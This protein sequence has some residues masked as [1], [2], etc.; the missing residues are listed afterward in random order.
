MARIEYY[1]AIVVH[2]STE[3]VSNGCELGFQYIVTLNEDDAFKETVD[4]FDLC[5]HMLPVTLTDATEDGGLF[6]SVLN[7]LNESLSN[8]I[9]YAIN[10]GVF[11]IEENSLVFYYRS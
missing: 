1:F 2:P 4:G 11:L 7:K 3:S 10:Q 9:F 8:P 5:K 6:F